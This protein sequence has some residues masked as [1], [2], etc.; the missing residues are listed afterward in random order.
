MSFRDILGQ[1][2][3][4]KV[5]TRAL[6][7]ESVAHAYIFQGGADYQ[8]DIAAR[9]FAKAL[10]CKGARRTEPCGMCESCRKI[11]AGTHPYVIEVMPDGMSMKIEQVKKVLRASS[12]S[13]EQGACKVFILHEAN[14]LT[15]EASNSLL[16]TFEEPAGRTVFI[17]LVNDTSTLLPTIVSRCQVV[18]FVPVG[19]EQIRDFLISAGI[20]EERAGVLSRLA[21]GSPRRALLM[22]QDEEFWAIR[23]RVREIIESLRRGGTLAEYD[24]IVQDRNRALELLGVL[25]EYFRDRLA[26]S[27]GAQDVMY[28]PEE[29]E[30][31]FC[32]RERQNAVK[33]L[34]CL[35]IIESMR[36]A[37]SA[38]ANVRL[39]LTVLFIKLRRA[40]FED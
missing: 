27:L 38:N 31:V 7:S 35:D 24:E 30:A 40:W 14:T 25:A 34:A 26:L 33:C 37:I 9:I 32:D 21:L 17:L 6:S 18:T 16:K 29:V 13:A 19:T 4:I 12:L 23:Q 39:A 28:N 8:A 36:R 20:P 1:E 15:I 11:D 3:A 5:L 10:N 2:K 22:A